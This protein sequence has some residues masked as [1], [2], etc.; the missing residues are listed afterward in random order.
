MTATELEA[1]TQEIRETCRLCN[2]AEAHRKVLA[3]LKSVQGGP[4]TDA[5]LGEYAQGLFDGILNETAVEYSD[6]H[7]ILPMILSALKSVAGSPQPDFSAVTLTMSP[8][9]QEQLA[10]IMNDD[11]IE[12]SEQL[13]EALKK[14]GLG[15]PA[16]EC[17]DRC[18]GSGVELG[19]LSGTPRRC[20]ACHGSKVKV[21]KGVGKQRLIEHLESI[22]GEQA[23]QIAALT[24]DL[25][26][27][28]RDQSDLH[29]KL[30]IK[31][32]R[33]DSLEEALRKARK[34][35]G[36][37]ILKMANGQYLSAFDNLTLLNATID[38]ALSSTE[39]TP[40]PP[41]KA[42]PMKIVLSAESVFAILAEHLQRQYP[43]LKIDP[44]RAN[45]NVQP[46][47]ILCDITGVT[48]V[49]DPEGKV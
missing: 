11:S 8:K 19:V 35:S 34:E 17:C 44:G 23:K 43:L 41:E 18:E 24:T 4:K 16:V 22:T 26:E 25:E 38:A 39:T 1:L 49:V 6:R 40:Q 7:V 28:Y 37:L 32:Q 9:D 3:A 46:L 13:C 33:I 27:S 31:R 45:F 12:P 10:Q 30:R 15:S 48:F 21:E 14:H 2:S 20:R 5:E 47:A 36:Q 42:A 29:E